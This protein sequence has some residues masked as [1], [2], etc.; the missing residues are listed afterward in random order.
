MKVEVRYFASVR[1]ALGAGE[2]VEIASGGDVA[3]LRDALAA[4]GGRHAESLG[5]QRVVRSARNRVL[6]AESTLLA[7]GDEVGFFPPV[8]GG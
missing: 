2:P 6:C 8:T 4:R 7:D 5:R 3:A 1:E